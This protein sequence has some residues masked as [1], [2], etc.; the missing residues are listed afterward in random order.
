L[1]ERDEP[2][3]K[4]ARHEAKKSDTLASNLELWKYSLPSPLDSRQRAVFGHWSILCVLMGKNFYRNST[5]AG[6]ETVTR[7]VWNGYCRQVENVRRQLMP[8]LADHHNL[9]KWMNQQAVAGTSAVA[10]GAEERIVGDG[11]LL[12]SPELVMAPTPGF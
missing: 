8:K 12:I 7:E 6:E 4:A 2:Y 3:W 9:I 1:N 5:L 10:K 11:T